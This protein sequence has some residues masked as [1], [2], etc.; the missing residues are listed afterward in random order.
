MRNQLKES[1]KTPV[2]EWFK[3]KIIRHDHFHDLVDIDNALNSVPEHLRIENRRRYTE[4]CFGH[5]LM[6]YREIHFSTGIVHRLLL[7][8][9]HHDGP[10][11]EMRF[12]LGKHSVRFSKVEFCLITGLK[13]GVIPDTARYDMYDAVK[14]CLLFMLNW[15][16]MGVDE[17]DKVSVWQWRL[18]EDLDA[19]DAFPWGAH[20]YRRSIY[21][22]KH[23]LD[24]RR[25][26]A[27][28]ELPPPRV[29]KWE[30]SQR[31][32]GRKLDGIFTERMFAR[33]ELVPTSVEMAQPYYEGIYLGG[34]LYDTDVSDIPSH[35]PEHERRRSSR[36]IDIEGAYSGPSDTEGAYLGPSDREGPYYG[37]SDMDGAYSGA[38][39]TEGSDQEG[40]SRSPVR[41][42]SVRFTLPRQPRP[43]GDSV[44]EGRDESPER[45]RRGWD[46]K[47]GEVMDAVQSLWVDVMEAIRK[48]DEKRDQQYQELLDMIRALQGQ[49]QGQTSQSRMDS[50]PFDD[51]HGDFSPISRTGTH[52]HGIDSQITHEQAPTTEA[53]TADTVSDHPGHVMTERTEVPG[54][55]EISLLEQ[56]PPPVL[57]DDSAGTETRLLVRE[58]PGGSVPYVLPHDLAHG[59][60]SQRTPPPIDPS[61]VRPLKRC[62]RNSP[63]HQRDTG[64]ES[65]TRRDR[66]SS[67][68]SPSRGD[69]RREISSSHHS[70]PHRDTRRHRS[71]SQRSPL[72][73]NP[74]RQRSSSLRTPPVESSS[75]ACSPPQIQ[76]Q[77]RVRRPGWQLMTPY[78]DLC[79]PKKPRTRPASSVH[80][81]K[82]YDLLDP[83][84]VTAYQA[85]KRNTTGEL[86]DVDI[87]IPVGVTWFQRFQ[88]NFIEL[89]D[90]HIDAYLL[91]LRKRQRAYPTVYAQRVNVLDS[92]FYSWLDIQWERM[93][94]S[95]VAAPPK[96]WSMLKHKWHDDDLKTVRGLVP[97]GNRPWHAVDW[98]MIPCNLGRNH[99]VLASVDLTQGKIYLLDP[100]RQE[101]TWE[102]RNKQVAC[103]R[104][105]I[106]SML[107]QV[108]FHSNRTKDDV[109]YSLSKK[110]FRMSIMDGSRGV[111]Q[112][113]QGY[114]CFNILLYLTRFTTLLYR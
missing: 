33:R 62:R 1:L 6:M 23:A 74:Q 69:T 75:G 83:D 106:P 18:V 2:R 3:G 112:Q 66:S 13:F 86:R 92:Q 76:R 70:P 52:Q 72:H 40:G 32:W 98:V 39:D 104:W 102:Y 11:D 60:S 107:H 68:R 90:A 91:I 57:P 95:G 54:G 58:L 103:L 21:C 49:G 93:F 65:N 16:L 22:F 41:H 113:H 29:L 5:F 105:F 81:F 36:P 51:H 88:T 8:E 50:P 108:E 47:F 9:L 20:V 43:R 61:A 37:P 12:L 42:Q 44:L 31:P 94:G 46:G 96:E 26:R 38:N 53:H 10:E 110:A 100:F 87:H 99:W 114:D 17:R 14:L 79:R 63:T 77:L 82:P 80:A 97:S 35:V 101:V 15:I 59:S 24:G 111:P 84:H 48:S 7:H 67:E 85:Y 73:S 45:H 28:S 109:T 25:E 89:E 64:R 4:L 71:S 30:L 19:F 55:T 34:S 56:V 78:T 27:I